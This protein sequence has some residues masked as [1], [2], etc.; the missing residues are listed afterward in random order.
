MSS[1]NFSFCHQL[2]STFIC[3]DGLYGLHSEFEVGQL[4]D[5]TQPIGLELEAKISGGRS[6]HCHDNQDKNVTWMEMWSTA[7]SRN[8]QVRQQATSRT[9]VSPTTLMANSLEELIDLV[10]YFQ[11]LAGTLEDSF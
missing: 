11:S 7:P 10:K 3:H 5:V 4:D 9:R 1:S 8:S 2:V 6:H